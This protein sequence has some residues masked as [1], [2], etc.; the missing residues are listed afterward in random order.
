M[1]AAIHAF[2]NVFEKIDPLEY[3]AENPPEIFTDLY[4]IYKISKPDDFT[5]SIEDLR[6]MYELVQVD[7]KRIWDIFVQKL[8]GYTGKDY[9]MR[10]VHRK[11]EGGNNSLISYS[12]K[13]LSEFQLPDSVQKSPSLHS[14]LT[15][16]ME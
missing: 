6:R 7:D 10:L 14:E 4:S 16:V 2:H 12:S 8:S 15:P 5:K 11:T 1:I 3:N 9:T 13:S